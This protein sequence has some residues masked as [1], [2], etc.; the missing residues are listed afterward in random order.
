M[1]TLRRYESVVW[2]YQLNVWQTMEQRCMWLT[3]VLYKY[4]RYSYLR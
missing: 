2:F 1:R 4:S 3:F